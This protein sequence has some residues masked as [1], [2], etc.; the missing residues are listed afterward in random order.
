MKTPASLAWQALRA[1]I[2]GSLAGG[3][4]R[5]LVVGGARV[6]TLYRVPQDELR[7]NW[8]APAL[9]AAPDLNRLTCAILAHEGLVP[10]GTLC[11][12][13]GP[14]IAQ[15]KRAFLAPAPAPARGGRGGAGFPLV[16]GH[17]G[18]MTTIELSPGK[19]ARG[20]PNSANAE[21][22][23]R[24]HAARLLVAERPHLGTEAL[25][26]MRAPTKVLAT[27]FWEISPRAARWQAPILLWLNSTYGILSFLAHATSSMGDIIKMKKDQLGDVPAPDPARLDLAA[28]A[29]LAQALGRAAISCRSAP[30]FARAAQGAGPRRAL[31]RFFAEALG[32]PPI[33]ATLYEALARDPVVTRRRL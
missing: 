25:L 12:A 20:A 30:E 21:A 11:A 17:Q 31:D 28:C 5:D 22:L 8:L 2:P 27:A 13:I 3:C 23:H 29:A 15:V 26:A 16:L 10:F 4:A 33:A 32:L 19:L 14:D 6:A 24:R 9:F 18:D 1:E 7:R